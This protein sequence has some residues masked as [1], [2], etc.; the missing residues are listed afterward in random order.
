VSLILV[1]RREIEEWRER[2]L[3]AEGRV[4]DLE[5]T[6]GVMVEAHR[7]HALR[8]DPCRCHR[9]GKVCAVHQ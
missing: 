1:E 3:A 9:R 4:R 7:D 8:P 5:H 6:V 2:A